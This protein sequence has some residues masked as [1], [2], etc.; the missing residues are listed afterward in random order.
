MM[1]NAD[2][3]AKVLRKSRRDDVLLAHVPD[4][5]KIVAIWWF[6]GVTAYR[7]EHCRAFG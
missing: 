5:F 2:A 1:E 7:I 3:A 6:P 4:R